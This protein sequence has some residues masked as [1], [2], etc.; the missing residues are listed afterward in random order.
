MASG[1]ILSN[2]GAVFVACDRD[3]DRAGHVDV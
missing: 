2:E 3:R 1:P